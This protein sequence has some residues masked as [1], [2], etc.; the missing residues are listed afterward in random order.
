ML[1]PS[2]S[3]SIKD[4]VYFRIETDYYSGWEVQK[5]QNRIRYFQCLYP[6]S[7]SLKVLKKYYENR[8][9][10]K[11][12]LKNLLNLKM[13]DRLKYDKPVNFYLIYFKLT[14]FLTGHSVVL[15]QS[16]IKNIRDQIKLSGCSFSKKY[17]KNAL[18]AI[19]PF[20]Q[21]EVFLK[22]RFNLDLAKGKLN[23]KSA[24][25]FLDSIDGQYRHE[26]FN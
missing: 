2:T 12:S 15:S 4:K 23:F 1:I 17:E 5:Y 14:K 24:F 26:F 7:T 16:L 18:E 9:K 20:Y 11:K 8:F 6:E 13:D 10:Q 19:K 21:M 25:N 22:S 3:Y